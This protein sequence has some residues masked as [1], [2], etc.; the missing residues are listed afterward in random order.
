MRIGNMIHSP[1]IYR[2][3]NRYLE[4][5]NFPIILSFLWIVYSGVYA[6]V[7]SGSRYEQKLFLQKYEYEKVFQQ[8]LFTG[9]DA[10]TWFDVTYY[11]LALE[12]FTQPSF[13]KGKVTITG[14]CH[15]DSALIL[16]FDLMSS[17]HVDSVLVNNHVCSFTQQS[18]S[19]NIP[20]FHPSTTGEVISID[21]FYEGVPIA[22]GFGSFI[23][24]SH[25][26][27]PWIYTLSEPYGAKEWWPCKDDPSDKAD[28]A[29]IIVTCDSNLK[30]GSEGILAS[31]TQNGNG[32]STYHWKER[33]P[34]ASYLISLAITNYV[35]FSNWFHYSETDSMEVL[36]YVLPE[37]DSTAL[38]SLPRTIDM[39]TIFSEL[40]GMYPFIKEKYGHAEFGRG[41]AME[42]QTMTSTT[43]FDENTIAH[44][45]AHQWF[46]DMITCRSWS[47]LWLNEGFA[48]YSTALYLERRYGI[49]SYWTYMNSQLD[50]A[51]T[52]Q[53]ELGNPDTANIQKLFSLALVY[54]KGASVLHM[55]RHVLGDSIFF[56]SLRTYATNPSLKYSTATTKDFQ[57]ICE[58]VSG[59]NLNYFF[60]EWI[61]GE[62]YPVY[63][64]SWTWKSLGDSS[65][66]ILDIGQISSRSNPVF[67]TMPIDIRITA[68]GRDTTRTVF[69]DLQQ[70]RFVIR[71]NERPSAVLLD[72]GGWIL[73]STIS[74]NDQLPSEYVL[75]QN[76]PNPFNST[77]NIVYRIRR[78]G[79]V[80][81]KIYD[82]LGREITTLVHARQVPGVY[83]YQWIPHKCTSGIYFYRLI[84]GDVSLQKKMVLLR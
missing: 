63:R 69:N 47:E 25:S 34:I 16:T 61:Y 60:Q 48:Q 22:T 53:S 9:T 26:G 7:S 64:Y 4:K 24:D 72:P 52:A 59:K 14:V 66:I 41:G 19:F 83:E 12:V 17:M 71:C 15:R 6:Q 67:F 55:L 46:G 79:K 74:D 58:G 37:H 84:T 70:Q 68:A 62:E 5:I 27:I 8:Q 65:V 3:R 44:E 39:L 78:Q 32:T 21:V 28:S 40:F 10:S 35:Q 50:Q 18:S 45:L 73:K 77:T 29:D 43:T 11:R 2:L 54:S 20:L 82:V 13:L 42:H 31:V 76:Y 23:F 80:T 81:L 30:V 49:D 36:N 33:Y 75:E 1:M 38:Q 57:S 56:H 51:Q